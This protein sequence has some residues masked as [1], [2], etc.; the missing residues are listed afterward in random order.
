MTNQ[1]V[2]HTH[3][4]FEYVERIYEEVATLVREVETLLA[5]TPDRFVIGRPSGYGIS[6]RG[7]TGI[8]P[9]NVTRWLMRQFAV[10]FIPEDRAK[11]DKGQTATK[12]TP[13]L[14][15]L[16]LRFIL[17]GYDRCLFDGHPLKE[18]TVLFGVL[19]DISSRKRK[20]FENVMAD[21]EYS[22]SKL[23]KALPAVEM[24]EAYF[25]LRGHLQ[26][27]ALFSLTD[28]AAVGRLLVEPLLAQY[29][30]TP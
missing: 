5:E 18:P 25:K 19:H 20:K 7:S 23:F 28:A 16:Y 11:M 2:E 22:E 15:V 21:L 3:I 29:R 12:L 24:D 10:C 13:E 17:D 6:T 14:R 26:R 9:R 30:K 1:L 4:A 27:L 8:E